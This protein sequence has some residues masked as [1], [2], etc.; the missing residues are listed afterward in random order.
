MIDVTQNNGN[1]QFFMAELADINYYN[2]NQRIIRIKLGES[3]QDTRY[4]DIY[5]VNGYDYPNPDDH[6]V[7]VAATATLTDTLTNAIR[8]GQDQLNH[9]PGYKDE[10][11]LSDEIPM[12]FGWL[13]NKKV[14][15]DTTNNNDSSVGIF[16]SK[17]SLPADPKKIKYSLSPALDKD[18]TTTKADSTS[19]LNNESVGI[20]VTDNSVLIKST[21]GAILVG[22]EGIS[23]LGNKFESNTKG[24]RGMM[25]DNPFAGWIPSTMMTVPLGIEMIPNYNAILQI[26]TAGR[27]VSKGMASIKKL[28]TNVQSLV[29]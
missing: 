1:Y 5:F 11:T 13:V 10:T 27:I 22:P 29:A 16:N 24:G 4:Y 25:Q 18:Y 15:V 9:P 3:E 14:K 28:T 2:N 7:L 19:D 6:Y 20:F 8:P 17:A 26:G 21:A 12:A 23:L